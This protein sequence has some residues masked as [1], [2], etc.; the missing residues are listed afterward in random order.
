MEIDNY[1]YSL[2]EFICVI[3]TSES[4]GILIILILKMNVFIVVLKG[5][6]KAGFH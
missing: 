3:F 5:S 1:M 6:L 2:R 4:F